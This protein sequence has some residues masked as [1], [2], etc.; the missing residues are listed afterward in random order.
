MTNNYVARYDKDNNPVL[1]KTH[2]HNV[3]NI[4]Y[5]SGVKIGV[6]NLCKLA[7]LLHD[8][9]KYSDA[10]QEMLTSHVLYGNK[11]DRVDHSTA[12]G[13]FINQYI[14]EKIERLDKEDTLSLIL[15]KI[16]SE[17]IS[18]AIYAHHSSKGLLD[19]YTYDY[20]TTY[21]SNI[22]IH[23]KN[24]EI[25]DYD[26]CSSRFLEDT[27]SLSQLENLVDNAIE[28]IKEYLQGY[29][30]EQLT[31]LEANQDIFY[32]S[33]FVYGCLIE[34][35]RRDTISSFYQ[36]KLDQNNLA[37]NINQYI[38]NF[39]TSME[40][41]TIVNDL[42]YIKSNN[43][44]HAKEASEKRGNLFSLNLPTGG[45]KTYNSLAFA[46]YKAKDEEKDRV[47]FV[48][49]FTAI[50]SQ[51]VVA[52]KKVLGDDVNILESHSKV[53]NGETL[54]LRV[55]DDTWSC[56]IVVTTTVG[57]LNTFFSTGTRNVRRLPALIN[58]VIVFDEVQSVPLKTLNFWLSACNWLS[59]KGN[60][61]LVLCTAT[62]PN[63]NVDV[64]FGGFVSKP[65]PIIPEKMMPYINK[66]FE[67]YRLKTRFKPSGS[68]PFG[69]NTKEDICK[70]I[71]E[72]I[73]EVKNVLYVFNTRV[74]VNKIYSTLSSQ[75]LEDVEIVVLTK[76]MCNKHLDSQ[77]NYLKGLLR[78]NKK[79]ICLSTT[80]IEAGV[81]ISFE[82]VCRSNAPLYNIIQAFGRGNRFGEYDT[83]DNFVFSTAFDLDNTQAMPSIYKGTLV[84]TRYISK[85]NENLDAIFT[86]ESIS[87]YFEDY[88]SKFEDTLKYPYE[89]QRTEGYLFDLIENDKNRRLMLGKI[90]PQNIQKDLTFTSSGFREISN[91]FEAIESFGT[92]IYVIYD[93]E[94]ENLLEQSLND[95][96]L[97]LK[98]V[99]KFMVN[100]SDKRLAELQNENK[101]YYLAEFDVYVLK[102]EHYNQHFGI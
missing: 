19:F 40:D 99:Q 98:N 41:F 76:N 25:I 91:N 29:S 23:R 92:D 53:S 37:S 54:N 4:A 44:N 78:E 31:K 17:V 21:Q 74:A 85:N 6:G 102:K 96:V 14:W 63:F 62:Q 72:D 20:E 27:M 64:L 47:I 83:I 26:T 18:N 95:E 45:G 68:N 10:F 22:Y 79:V 33:K 48:I 32:L 38:S 24:K 9:G 42:D 88:Y 77:L 51:T 7:G 59:T 49:P 55:I 73:S 12:G 90:P 69:Y 3:S 16:T 36:K 65:I 94:A 52:I 58:S 84:T 5:D 93:E 75:N 67:R 30:V 2:L 61:T 43:L 101:V 57:F 87:N 60:T 56:D 81:D 71:L 28:E 100:V 82:R 50:I 70:Y 97:S 11:K 89:V 1:L 35:D 80:L 86:Q 66:K 15:Y 39:D 46:L 34:S 13:H 8:F